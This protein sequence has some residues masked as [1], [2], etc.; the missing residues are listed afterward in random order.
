MTEIVFF[1]QFEFGELLRLPVE[2]CQYEIL[3]SF[4][5]QWVSGEKA[6]CKA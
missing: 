6:F 3:I 5:T 4:W 2:M 1:K